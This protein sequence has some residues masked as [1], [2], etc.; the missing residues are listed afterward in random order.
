MDMDEMVFYSLDERAIKQE[1]AYKK[2]NLPT[3]DVLFSWVCTPK[4][5]FFEELHVLL[6]IVVPPLLFIL[7]ME[8]DDNFIYAFI[9]FVIFFLFGLY[10]RFTIFQPKTYSYELTKV[11][12]RYTIEENVHENFYKFSRAGGK[13]AAFVSVIAVIFLGPLALAGAG[14]GLLHARAMSNHRKRTEYET[15]IM[16]NSFRVRYHRARQEVAINPRHEKEM[17]SIGMY[18]FGTREDIHISPDKL[19]QLLFYLKKEF[20][21][22]DIKEAKTHKELNREYLN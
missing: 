10:Y 18:S 7:Q 9:F 8:E 22:I 17:M 16:P 20:D 2:E 12:I 5:L 21:V 6:M 15:H 3:A 13:L 1:I 11:G 19:Y 4:R 14:A